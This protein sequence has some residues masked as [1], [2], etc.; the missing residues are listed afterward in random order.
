MSK[1]TAGVLVG[2]L[3]GIANG[4]WGARGESGAAAVLT[5]VLGRAS[6]GIINGILAAY[7]TPGKPP[8][9]RGALVGALIGAGLGILS[10]IPGRSWSES[11]PLGSLVGLGCGVATSR[12]GTSGPPARAHT[13]E[14]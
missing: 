3:L 12:A 13:P 1:V 6:Q 9:W 14:A 10:G 5:T 2:I 4:F 8:I 11:I 7:A